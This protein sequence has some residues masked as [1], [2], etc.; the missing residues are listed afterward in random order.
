MYAARLA[1]EGLKE[2]LDDEDPDFVE[3]LQKVTLEAVIGV[4]DVEA[5]RELMRQKTA[6]REL[7]EKAYP[8]AVN[9]KPFTGG[10]IMYGT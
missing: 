2:L 5:I 7:L 4:A 6:T 8:P 9:P 3:G 10:P 1:L